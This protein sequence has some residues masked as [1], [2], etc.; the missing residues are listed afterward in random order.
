VLLF[1][2]L[3]TLRNLWLD[4][5][6]ARPFL[7]SFVV[8]VAAVACWWLFG[9]VMHL[10]APRE[11]P[12]KTEI[13]DKPTPA[14]LFTSQ[15]QELLQDFVGGKDEGELW[16]LFDLHGITTFNIRRAKAS[17]RPG[18]LTPAE[19]AEIDAFFR[20]GQVYL[21][22]RY[23]K[24]V[25]TAG[26]FRAEPIPGKLSTLNLS[27]KYVTNRQTLAKFQSS[28]QVPLAVRNALKELDEAVKGNV[29]VL[30]SV[31][32][33]K[34]AENPDNIL[35]EENANSPLFGATSGAFLAKRIWLKPKQ[36]A[37]MSA[38]T[39]YLKTQ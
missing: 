31:I 17:I 28:P 27:R 26:G 23:C 16:E 14:W 36:E 20:D 9:L 10:S 29:Q 8:A 38:I 25:R 39:D 18:S 3:E 33:D 22:N 34:L 13:A 1:C 11:T 2:P 30:L 32:N 37:V 7:S 21:D 5:G 12:S 24:V 15:I 35:C 4:Y 6:L 19:V